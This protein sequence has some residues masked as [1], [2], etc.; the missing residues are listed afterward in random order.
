MSARCDVLYLLDDYNAHG[1]P[2]QRP[3]RTNAFAAGRGEQY[4]ITLR[5]VNNV[6]LNPASINFIITIFISV[7]SEQQ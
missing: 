6:K 4:V 2:A 1:S 7:S 5:S 3:R